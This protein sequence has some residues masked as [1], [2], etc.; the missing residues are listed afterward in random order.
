[1]E[2]EELE[3]EISY[4]PEEEKPREDLTYRFLI[5][6]Q[7]NDIR[8]ILNSREI[9]PRVALPLIDVLEVMLSPIDEETKIKKAEI[10]NIDREKRRNL[11]AKQLEENQRQL[12]FDLILNLYR[13]LILLAKKRGLLYFETRS[14][15]LGRKK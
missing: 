10:L 15:Y 6:F 13:I 2:F 14:L 4:G 1:M 7:I 3:G 12:D 9:E 5:M 8:K 11:N